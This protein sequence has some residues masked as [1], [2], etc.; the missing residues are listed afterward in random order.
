MIFLSTIITVTQK[1]KRFLS[2][3]MNNFNVS[4]QINYNRF[5]CFYIYNLLLMFKSMQNHFFINLIFNDQQSFNPKKI[6]TLIFTSLRL[7][8]QL[9]SF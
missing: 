1:E 6:K 3:L 7:Q 9:L 5:K 2:K 8:I 4:F